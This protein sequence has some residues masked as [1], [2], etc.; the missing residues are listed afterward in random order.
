[1]S[2][3]RTPNATLLGYIGPYFDGLEPAQALYKGTPDKMNENFMEIVRRR[4][5]ASDPYTAKGVETDDRYEWRCAIHFNYHGRRITVLMPGTENLDLTDGT[6]ADRHMALYYQGEQVSDEILSTVTM[7]V[8]D[9]FVA[10]Y[11]SRYR[12]LP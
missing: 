7:K 9:A 11:R 10:A 5:P 1:M 12:E 8:A 4:L 6:Y 2:N 3:Q